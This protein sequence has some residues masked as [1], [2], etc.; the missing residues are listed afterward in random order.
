MAHL[1][2]RKV[3]LPGVSVL[4]RAISSTREHAS[5]RLWQVLAALPTPPQRVLLETLLEVPPGERQTPLNRLRRGPT[6]ASV[7]ALVSALHRIEAIRLFEMEHLDLSFIPRGRLKALTRHATTTLVQHL[8]HLAPNR[9]IA[10]L[11]AFTST[12]LV[13]MHDDALDLFDVLMRTTVS[14]ATREGQQERLRTIHD[15]DA[16]AQILAQACQ[17][18]LDETHDPI[19]L[20]E[21]IYICVPAEH[22]RAAVTTVGELLDRYLMMRR[23]LPTFWRTLEFE[24][25]SGGRP[26]LQ[27]VQFLQRIEGRLERLCSEIPVR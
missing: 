4:E 10:T 2:D 7:P 24:S 9:R 3:L 20:L 25:T 16:A 21:R 15:L 1:I 27:A 19:T 26:T 6:R 14:T 13:V 18:V 23:F 5:K 17:I 12:Y 8:R 11:L 22:L